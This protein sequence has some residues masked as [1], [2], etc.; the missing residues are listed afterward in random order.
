[1]MRFGSIALIWNTIATEGK[2]NP[3]DLEGSTLTVNENLIAPKEDVNGTIINIGEVDPSACI[4]IAGRFP[5]SSR[6][7]EAGN[8]TRKTSPLAI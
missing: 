8:P 6:R 5:F 4:A 3:F 1:M 7:S 2:D